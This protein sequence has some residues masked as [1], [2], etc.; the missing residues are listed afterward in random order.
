MRRLLE[1]LKN[2]GIPCL[3]NISGRALTTFKIGGNCALI[4]EPTCV[5]E[6]LHALQICSENGI[7]FSVI[8]GGSNLLIADD[9]VPHALI[10]TSNLQGVFKTENGFRVLCGTPTSRLVRHAASSGSDTLLFAA[11]IPGTVGGAL[12]MNAGTGG[13]GML[14]LVSEV[15]TIDPK[16]LQFKTYIQEKCNKSYRKSVFQ[17]NGEVIAFAEF[18]L[19]FGGNVDAII[20]QLQA[21]LL[22]RKASQPLELPSAGS[23]FKRTFPDLPLSKLIDEAGLCGYRIGDAAVSTKHAGF[24]VNL[25][26]ATANDVK[27]LMCH[28]QTII[29]RKY[30]VFP[31]PEIRMLPNDNEFCK[32][33][34]G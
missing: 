15:T 13:K 24:I 4:I 8:G 29:E 16:T 3:E 9:G 21:Q 25:G 6:L 12:F 20:N 7:C 17:E 26:N 33:N 10:R 31:I 18:S 19:K 34:E 27:M 11:G 32:G 2:E 28:I 14:D 23:T 5:G 22:R 1:T 30:G